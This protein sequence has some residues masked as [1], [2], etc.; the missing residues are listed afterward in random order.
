MITR[1]PTRSEDPG[2]IQGSLT[3]RHR[4]HSIGTS[5]PSSSRMRPESAEPS[6]RTLRSERN[7][8]KVPCGHDL[9]LHFYDSLFGREKAHSQGFLRLLHSQATVFGPFCLLLEFTC[10]DGLDQLSGITKDL[11][12]FDCELV[13][14]Q[15]GSSS[16]VKKAI[17]STLC[18]SQ[19]CLRKVV[20][21][22]WRTILI[23]DGPHR[24]IIP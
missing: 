17:F 9:S 14:A 24:F 18:K 12:K 15:T 1:I 8:S 23:S 7:V 3:Q 4:S 16:C 5:L 19:Q 10:K 21:E 2:M 20:S 13:A 6:R 11:C 22:G